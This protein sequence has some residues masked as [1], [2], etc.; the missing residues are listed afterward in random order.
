MLLLNCALKLVEEIILILVIYSTG[1]IRFFSVQQ[2]RNSVLFRLTIV[3]FYEYHTQLEKHAFG[4]THLNECS[5]RRRGCNLQNTQQT[6]EKNIHA[7]REIQTRD[8][9]NRA[10]SDLRLKPH[11]HRDE[12]FA[13]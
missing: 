6:Q 2:Q 1:I 5:A 10:A 9:S 13:Y 11:G 7:L 8:P 3:G 4:S 12:Q